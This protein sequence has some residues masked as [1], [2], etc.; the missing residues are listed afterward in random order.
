MGVGFNLDMA[1]ADT[2]RTE[3]PWTDCAPTTMIRSDQGPE[4]SERGGDPDAPGADYVYF[5]P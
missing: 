3:Q 1:P 2:G 5:T 4:Q